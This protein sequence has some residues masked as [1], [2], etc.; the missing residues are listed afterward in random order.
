MREV[1]KGVNEPFALA[2]DSK[3]WLYVANDPRYGAGES[4]GSISVYAPGGSQPLGK[5][6]VYNPVALA[7]DPSDSVYVANPSNHSSVLV[8]SNGPTKLLRTITSGVNEPSALLI[9][10]P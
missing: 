4:L 2:L 8:Y 5:V 9:D 6:R 7:L 1:T 3:G 10:S